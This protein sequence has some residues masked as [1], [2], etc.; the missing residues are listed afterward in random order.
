MKTFSF[1][2]VL[3]FGNALSA[4][5]PLLTP[6]NEELSTAMRTL[7]VTAVPDPLVAQDMGWG[8]QKNVT[9]GV[10]W[11][12]RGIFLKPERQMKLQND[13]MWRRIRIEADDPEK[14]LTLLVNNIRQVE[15]GRLLFDVHVTM[16]TKIKF[17][18]QLWTRGTRVYSGETRARCRP[19][20]FLECENTTKVVKTGKFLPD[21]TMRMRVLKASL[22]YDQFVVDHTAGVGGD[23]AKLVGEGVFET[24]RTLRP[25]LEKDMLNKANEAIVKAGDTKE[26]KVSFAK[27]LDSME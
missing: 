18:Q 8:D 6:T 22:N 5:D 15:K 13:G 1:L 21:I 7:L 20:V 9:N 3:I 17:E 19:I 25:S 2:C 12:K 27:F 26:I 24:V 14:N 4:Q 10:T 11:K 16:K 23:F